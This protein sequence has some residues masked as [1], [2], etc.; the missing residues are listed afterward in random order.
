MFSFYYI[1]V[2][3]ASTGSSLEAVIAGR[4]PD[5]NP[6]AAANPVPKTIFVILRTNSKS[7]TLVKIMAIAQTNNKPMIPPI[8]ERIMA[9]NKN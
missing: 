9:S 8:R 1:P 4:I 3:I 6:I 5:I 7:N 2:R